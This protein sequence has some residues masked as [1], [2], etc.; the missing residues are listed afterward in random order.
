[1]TAGVFPF[2]RRLR[3]LGRSRIQPGTLHTLAGVYSPELDTTRDVYVYLPSGYDEDV[4]RYP[5]VYMH[6]AQNL[7]DTGTGFLGS[8]YVEEAVSAA[9]RLGHPCIVVGVPHAGVERIV[10][11]SPFD[12]AN[13]GAGRGDLYLDFLV[14]TLKPQI[15]KQYRTLRDR[16]WTGIAGSSMGGLISLYAAFTRGDIFGFAG[17]LSPS[18][19]FAGAAIFPVIETA[20]ATMPEA[21]RPRVYLDVGRFD[22]ARAVGDARRM[23]DL[24]IE[25]GYRTG[26]DLR[27]VEDPRGGHNEAAWA[28]RFRKALPALLAA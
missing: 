20:L 15:D 16:R 8:W 24:L 11:Y 3:R 18:F 13:F 23:R 21:D 25:N 10:E 1:M 17:A 2:I 7:F 28:R 6:D 4:R 27:W 5:V 26:E 22:G 9:T 14:E 12:D 19:W